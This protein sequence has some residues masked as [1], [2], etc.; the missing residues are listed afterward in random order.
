MEKCIVCLVGDG[1][2]LEVMESVKEVLYMVER[3]YGYYFYL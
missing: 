1:V 2:G 3:L